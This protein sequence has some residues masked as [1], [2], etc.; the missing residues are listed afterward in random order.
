MSLRVCFVLDELFPYTKGG[1]GRLMWN[2]IQDSLRRDPKFTAHILWVA[3]G[4]L[5][6]SESPRLV[7]HPL[8]AG[9]RSADGDGIYAP[10][11][12]YNNLW[13]LGTSLRICHALKELEKELGPFSAIE[14]PDF[15]GWSVATS[16]ERRLG[17]AFRETPIVV[18][19]HG[20]AAL[21]AHFEGTMP[22][23]AHLKL[24][25]IERKSFETADIV[26][27]H[28][29]SVW[30]DYERIYQFAKDL[31]PVIQ[32]PQA[33][34]PL[35][36]RQ[37][38]P[39]EGF[40]DIVFAGRFLKIKRPDLF[41]RGAIAFLRSTPHYRGKVYLCA[42]ASEE[43]IATQ[44]HALVP[45]EMRER[46]I[47]STDK[48]VRARVI[49]R[50]NVMVI[51]ST[52]EG[53]N[54]VAYESA[55]EGMALILNGV[56]SAF[57]QPRRFRDGEN[58]FIFDGTVDGLC[59][60]LTRAYNSK[61]TQT[62]PLKQDEPYFFK[63]PKASTGLA[64]P[65]S[66]L[67]R[68]KLDLSIVLLHQERTHLI[69]TTLESLL[70]CIGV[71]SEIIVIGD[72]TTNPKHRRLL[73]DLAW[74]CAEADVRFVQSR[75]G[76]SVAALRN[77][78]AKLAKA[79]YL[80]FI[81]AGDLVSPTFLSRSVSALD[82]HQDFDVV[83]PNVGFFLTEEDAK[84]RRFSDY[85]V[86][87]GD[88]PNVG[89][90]ENRC[91][92]GSAVLRRSLFDEVRYDEELVPYEEWAFF[93]ELTVK[94]KR[95]LLTN[96]ISFFRR[97]QDGLRDS[98]IDPEQ[99]RAIIAR[100]QYQVARRTGVRPSVDVV[101]CAAGGDAPPLTPTRPVSTAQKNISV[102]VVDRINDL[103]KRFP[104]QHSLARRALQSLGYGIDGKPVR[105]DL[106]EKLS[107]QL[108]RAPKLVVRFQS[109]RPS[110]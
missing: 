51:P 37:V 70:R 32:F 39:S 105:H 17:T 102:E 74:R 14:F 92:P 59:S 2:I 91:S 62:I 30:K 107:L 53:L 1:I 29:E 35:P 96:Q 31:K 63:L 50:G 108:R 8:P 22:T 18:R 10:E 61:L 94:K 52:F 9:T 89:W 78:G 109:G 76:R 64:A 60:S 45:E 86:Y 40:R 55:I 11:D 83:V 88:A 15:R 73:D 66:M 87:L 36:K 44:C 41:V 5:P 90:L 81:D 67:P 95:F 24:Y 98:I 28:V 71:R 49:T 48:D 85:A 101:A 104:A 33:V 6:L 26:V 34:Y 84:A 54:L 57:Q 79:P 100:M 16:A 80:F 13:P 75:G 4:E 72:G 106:V 43:Q 42:F 58:C 110:A 77:Q 47:F 103:L 82:H 38:L 65:K 27:S 97:G 19:C 20:S 56:C 99:E 93:L 21:I 23:R 12:R 25:D 68:R 3:G 69:P 46:F 7:I